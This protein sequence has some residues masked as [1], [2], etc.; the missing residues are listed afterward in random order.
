[1]SAAYPE[2]QTS[3]LTSDDLLTVMKLALTVAGI[4]TICGLVAIVC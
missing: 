4:V 2:S 1:M 3:G